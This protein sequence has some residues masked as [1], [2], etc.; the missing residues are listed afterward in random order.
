[1]GWLPNQETPFVTSV[2]P[3]DVVEIDTVSHEGILEDQGRD[4]VAFFTRHGV[5]PA[6]VLDDALAMAAP[7][8]TETSR[9]R[10]R[11]SSTDRSRCAVPRSATS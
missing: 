4:P 2:D 8:S 5:D 11:T 1:M 3:G 9:D 7:T 6:E 10:D